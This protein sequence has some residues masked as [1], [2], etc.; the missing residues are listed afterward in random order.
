MRD[1]FA[2]AYPGAEWLGRIKKLEYVA[3][4][5]PDSG[6]FANA[7]VITTDLDF[8]TEQPV[9]Q[10]IVI[11]LGEAHPAWAKQFVLKY[12]DGA[13]VSAGDIVDTTP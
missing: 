12:A 8:K 2:A 3:G 6:G 4:E 1:W 10:E 5:V 7:V 13:N 9:A 11:A